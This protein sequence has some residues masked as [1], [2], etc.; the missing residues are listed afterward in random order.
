MLRVKQLRVAAAGGKTLAIFMTESSHAGSIRP[1]APPV[2]AMLYVE[3]GK[4]IPFAVDDGAGDILR[5]LILPSEKDWEQRYPW[6]S[7]RREQIIA[8]IIAQIRK[9][10]PECKVR[11]YG[12][13]HVALERVHTKFA[14]GNRRV[15]K[16]ARTV[17]DI[18]AAAQA[19]FWPL[20]KAVK[21]SRAI[22][23][24]VAVFQDPENGQIE[25]SGDSRRQFWDWNKVMDYTLYYPYHFPN[26]FAA[27]LLPKDL[28]KGEEVWLEDL[29]EDVVAI[30]GNQGYYP[31]LKEGLAIWNGTDLELQFNPERD[32]QRWIG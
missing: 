22:S 31:R 18:N 25:I 11:I 8:F 3:D 26:P 20:V 12:E 16:T 24:M 15:I 5:Q 14:R 7:G 27:Y 32:A 9:D 29:I 30:Q 2:G 4:V 23:H 19:G 10:L 21:P 13:Y 17:A 6:A 1:N 28:A